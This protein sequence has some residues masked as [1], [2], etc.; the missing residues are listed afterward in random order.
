MSFTGVPTKK[1]VTLNYDVLE[2]IQL[3][4]KVFFGTIDSDENIHHL[5][6][7]M[8]HPLYVYLLRNNT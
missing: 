3:L 5:C 4:F 8:G 6:F 1:L 7:R 2:T